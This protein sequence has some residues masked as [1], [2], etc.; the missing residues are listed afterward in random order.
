MFEYC[1]RF[2]AVSCQTAAFLLRNLLMMCRRVVCSWLRNTADNECLVHH[3]AENARCDTKQTK[4]FCVT[5]KTLSALSHN[6]HV[7][8]WCSRRCLLC[9]RAD[10]VCCVTQQK[11]LPYH[12]AVSCVTEQ[13][14]SAASHVRY[15]QPSDLACRATPQTRSTVS[16]SVHCLLCCKADNVCCL[17]Q[18]TLF[19]VSHS[20]RCRLSHSRGA[21]IK[22]HVRIGFA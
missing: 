4:A 1:H 17:Q 14:L 6:R 2:C 20:R 22:G 16:H 10:I 5:Q 11:S 21:P 13:T 18:Q 15:C 3:P 8:M 12:A 9:D 7:V 19:V